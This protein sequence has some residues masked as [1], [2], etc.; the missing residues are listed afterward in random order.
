MM[1]FDF[2]SQNVAQV[3]KCGVPKQCIILQL[4]LC[5]CHCN[6]THVTCTSVHAAP[7]SCGGRAGRPTTPE[8]KGGTAKPTSP[9]LA[10]TTIT[11]TISIRQNSFPLA[12]KESLTFCPRPLPRY[13]HPQRPTDTPPD[14][15]PTTTHPPSCRNEPLRAICRP[16]SRR[17]YAPPPPTAIIERESPRI[18]ELT[19]GPQPNSSPRNKP[20]ARQPRPQRPITS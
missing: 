13:R 10:T 16:N 12:E 8:R 14:S 15:R 20:A 7:P 6:Q 9:T 19:M 4:W 3:P 18:P 5:T 2:P 17:E 11:T 1:Q